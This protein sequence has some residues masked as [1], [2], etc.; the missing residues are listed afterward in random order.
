[1]IAAVFAFEDTVWIVVQGPY[2]A[3]AACADA[4]I[5]VVVLLRIHLAI[6]ADEIFFEISRAMV[7]SSSFMCD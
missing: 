6:V 7:L 3:A 5:W 4:A 1:M 2:A